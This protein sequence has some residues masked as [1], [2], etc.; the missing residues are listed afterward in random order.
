MHQSREQGGEDALRRLLSPEIRKWSVCLV[1]AFVLFVIVIPCL[2]FAARS[3]NASLNKQLTGLK[4]SAELARELP[5]FQ[6]DACRSNPQ[7]AAAILIGLAVSFCV[8]CS[9]CACQLRR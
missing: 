6:L 4:G 2:L 9:F 7:T 3:D 8:V 5:I 1:L